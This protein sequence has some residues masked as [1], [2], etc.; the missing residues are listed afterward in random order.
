MDLKEFSELHAS[1]LEADEV[2]FNLQLAVLANAPKESPP[3]FRYWTLG[4]PGHC[5]F[6]WPGRAIV[7]GDLKKAECE[8]LARQTSK[9]DYPGVVGSDDMPHWFVEQ[10]VALGAQFEE[11]VPQSIQVIRSAPRH[12]RA[13]GEARE[14]GEADAPLVFEWLS[15][16]Q[17]E[18]VP[19]DPPPV[20]AN[21]GKVAASGRLLFWT[22][23]DEPVSMAAVA[24][25][26][27]NT[28]AI[29]PVYTP[30]E[31]R[32]R[33]YAGAVTAAVVDKLLAEG[34]TAVCLY[35]DLRNPMS[36]RC[37]AKIG[38]TRHCDSWHYLRKPAAGP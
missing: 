4:A 34:K 15:A 11:P 16:F 20:R 22:V 2:R 19:H 10:A 28:G 30:P 25:R 12:P 35:T 5:A 23:E 37:Y 36:N 32:G 1:A 29:A 17:Q 13:S 26:L 8:E 7:L 33:G 27:R 9:V 24:R 31:H 3:G 21:A 38:F 6:Q 18:A 14:T